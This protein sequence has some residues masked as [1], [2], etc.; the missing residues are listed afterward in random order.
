MLVTPS[1]ITTFAWQ[2]GVQLGE[3]DGPGAG[4]VVVVPIDGDGEEDGEGVGV[5]LG[6][7]DG[8]GAGLVVVVPVDGDGEEDGEG[9]GAAAP[10]GQTWAWM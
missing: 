5:Q 4:L 3:E 9:L 6:E 8:L 1:G 2:V 10:P 7:E